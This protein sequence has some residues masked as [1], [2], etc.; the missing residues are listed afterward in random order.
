MEKKIEI[1]KLT[2]LTEEQIYGKNKLNIFNVMNPRAV[3]SDTAILRGAFVS[4]YHVDY[5]SSPKGRTGYYWLQNFDKNDEIRG[6]YC[7]GLC[8][9][10]YYNN[11]NVGVR[12]A[13]PYS[14]IRSLPHTKIIGNDGLFRIQYGYY[15][16]L[17]VDSS[18]QNVLENAYNVGDLTNIGAGCI[19]DGR[20]YDDYFKNFITE[21]QTYF[22]YNGEVYA[23]I[24]ANLDLTYNYYFTLSNGEKYEIGDFVW[25]KVE[26]IVW[27]KHPLDDFMISKKVIV[28]GVMF[29]QNKYN[30]DFSETEMKWFLDNHLSKDILSLYELKK[31]INKNN[32]SDDEIKT[33]NNFIY[34]D[35]NGKPT[36]KKKI[37]VKA[38]RKSNN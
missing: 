11:R 21:K 19:F 18:M 24:R 31:D 13:L 3:V 34:L 38:K 26:P 5:D 32:Y 7:N 23:R 36:K 29:N 8:G 20:R 27:L 4:D 12:V 30:G 22:E 16:G 37:I 28:A 35:E 2:L 6:V 1:P 33:I 9:Y 15:P 10:F 25:V 17:A 14:Q